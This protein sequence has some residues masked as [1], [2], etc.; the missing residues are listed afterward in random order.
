MNGNAS[1]GATVT[2]QADQSHVGAAVPA[3]VGRAVWRG[4]WQLIVDLR[5]LL[6]NAGLEPS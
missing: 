2:A 4:I 1:D 5:R 3:W 6:T